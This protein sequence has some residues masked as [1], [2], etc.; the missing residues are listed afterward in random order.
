MEWNISSNST[1]KISS[2]H[3]FPG[4]SGQIGNVVELLRPRN[5]S[6]NF[7]GIEKFEASD[8]FSLRNNGWSRETF[9]S[10]VPWIPYFQ[11]TIVPFQN[12][13]IYLTKFLGAW[14]R[15]NY[16]NKIRAF[17]RV[18]SE[19][20]VIMGPYLI[21]NRMSNALSSSNDPNL[22]PPTM[23]EQQSTF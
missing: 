22:C 7:E 1:P 19:W 12:L 2:F 18:G 8:R 16:D 10:F 5:F 11:L 17:S 14:A 4:N 6:F 23:T 13:C 15:G 9:H 21:H 3:Y 20:R